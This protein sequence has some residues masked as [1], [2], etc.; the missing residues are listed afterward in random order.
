MSRLVLSVVGFAGCLLA[1][2]ALAQ[3]YGP[4]GYDDPANY[5]PSLAP[6]PGQFGGPQVGPQYAQP[7]AF[8]SQ[9]YSPPQF[10]PQPYASPNGPQ[11]GSRGRGYGQPRIRPAVM[12]QYAAP[13]YPPN[14]YGGYAPNTA[15]GGYPAAGGF[16]GSSGFGPSG[17][18]GYPNN[19]SCGPGCS[20]NH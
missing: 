6:V 3:Q 17:I 11:F 16:S 9:P 13:S 4:S 14:A 19:G 20:H 15:P 7:Y 18:P 8:H 10:A 1:S 2:S 5:T 12:Q